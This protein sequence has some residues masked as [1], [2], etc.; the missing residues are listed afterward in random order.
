VVHGFLHRAREGPVVR[1]CL[2]R[3]ERRVRTAGTNQE[4]V[5]SCL[6]TKSAGIRLHKHQDSDARPFSLLRFE[7]GKDRSGEDAV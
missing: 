5:L 6:Q 7:I 3:G 4:I 1:A 2:I